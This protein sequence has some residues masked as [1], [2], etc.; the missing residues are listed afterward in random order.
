RGWA[1]GE[2]GTRRALRTRRVRGGRVGEPRACCVQPY[3]DRIPR[4]R[5]VAP[6]RPHDGRA[7]IAVLVIT[8][9]IGWMAAAFCLALYLGERGR[10]RDLA[11]LVDRERTEPQPVAVRHA[12]DAE[13]EAIRAAVAV[14]RERLIED[15]VAE[16]GC[17]REQAEAEADR[18]IHQVERA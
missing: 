1:G 6:A 16:T 14:E 5:P 11:W 3:S 8:S 4:R 18:I 10:R 9:A 17:T 13:G 15:L 7:M 12:P 2:P